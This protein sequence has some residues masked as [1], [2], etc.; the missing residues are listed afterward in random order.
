MNW[1]IHRQLNFTM[2]GSSYY[3]PSE[4]E[5]G[6]A[7]KVYTASM[8]LAKSFVRGKV[9]GTLD[10]AFRKEANEYTEYAQDNYDEDIW[11]ARV[12]LNYNI[13]RFV[14]LFGRVEFQTE[15]TQGRYIR[16]NRYDYDRWR[17]TLGLRLTY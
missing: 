2:L 8:G 9:T 10:L 11:T 17:A 13:N 4:R 5:F 1:R 15:D 6:K 14:S 3:Q 12:G 16:N 7:I